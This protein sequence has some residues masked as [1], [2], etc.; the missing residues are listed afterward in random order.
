L[1]FKSLSPY[2]SRRSR[3]ILRDSLALILMFRLKSFDC[4]GI[5]VIRSSVSVLQDEIAE[6][7]PSKISGNAEGASFDDD[8]EEL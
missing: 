3:E 8:K 2:Q 5:L 1:A 6:E 7:E 4:T